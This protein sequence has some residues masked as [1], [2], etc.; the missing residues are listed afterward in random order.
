MGQATSDHK[1]G[2]VLAFIKLPL[3][4]GDSFWKMSF[5]DK[6]RKANEVHSEES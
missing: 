3:R 1:T 6:V 2:E 4:K 5:L